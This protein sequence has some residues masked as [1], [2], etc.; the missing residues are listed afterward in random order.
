[1]AGLERLSRVRVATARE[2]V[3]IYWP[4]RDELLERAWHVKG[5]GELR[6]RFEEVGETRPAKLDAE[7]K[8]VAIAVIEQWL[9]EV[10]L[11]GLPPGI[12]HLRNALVADRE[13]DELDEGLGAFP[14]RRD[15]PEP[16]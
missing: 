6:R 1:V 9:H 16:A 15:L 3:E 5:S 14:P 4:A 13:W 10:G 11:D 7:S 12:F 2:V 8:L